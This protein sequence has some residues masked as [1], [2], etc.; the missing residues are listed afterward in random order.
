MNKLLAQ[1]ITNPALG[2]I[3]TQRGSAFVP[4]L[5]TALINLGFVAGSLFFLANLIMGGIKWTESGGDK[6]K[7]E[8]ARAQVTQSV[9]GAIVL[10]SAYAIMALVEFFFSVDLT[11]FNLDD[12]RVQG[13]G[14][15]NAPVQCPPGF[16]GPN[17]NL[18]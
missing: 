6:G 18:Q 16:F 10:F 14:G 9:V 12:L 1:N 13:S 17:C 11:L 15:A 2:D 8:E 7:I 3:A 4:G 5:I